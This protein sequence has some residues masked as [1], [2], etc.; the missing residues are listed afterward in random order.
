V[1]LVPAD[2]KVDAVLVEQRAVLLPQ[3]QI[4]AVEVSRADHHLVHGHDDPV[5]VTRR[6]GLRAGLARGKRE[7]RLVRAQATI[8]VA[9][10]AP[11]VQMQ[12]VYGRCP[13]A[14]GLRPSSRSGV[15]RPDAEQRDGGGC[16]S[17]TEQSERLA[18]VKG[19][20]MS[21]M[22]GKVGIWV[23]ATLTSRVRQMALF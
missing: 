23:N 4:R 15:R 17:A 21:L 13:R 1:V 5:D 14:T 22:P 20:E 2:D 8:W 10:S 12:P 7:V 11:K 3:A 18:T 9:G 6:A 19:G 16:P